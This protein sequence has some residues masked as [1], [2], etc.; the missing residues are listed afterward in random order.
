MPVRVK[1]CGVADAL[2]A[3]RA[4]AAGADALGFVFSSSPRQVTPED[5]RRI[6]AALPPFVATVGVFVDESPEI[7][8][9]VAS[10]CRLSC[11]QIQLWPDDVGSSAFPVPAILTV[12]VGATTPWER[13]ERC[14]A[15]AFLFDSLVPGQGGGSGVRFDWSLLRGRSFDRPVVIAG[16]L[17]PENV[18]DAVEAVRPFGV[19]VSSGVA[20][21][22]P[23]RKDPDKMDAFV[24][25]AKAP[26]SAS[27]TA[28]RA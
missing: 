20:S 17:T 4:V 8:A 23:R 9:N 22:D 18:A 15:A 26:H 2:S 11:V 5:A 7:V 16:G 13:L 6:V 24:R 21:S 14:D 27:F 25:A 28:E 3:Q 19:D 1:I 10:H 12:R